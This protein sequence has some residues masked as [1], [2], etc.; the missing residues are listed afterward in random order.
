MNPPYKFSV[1]HFCQK[2]LY[3]MMKKRFS[4]FNY[5]TKQLKYTIEKN[6]I[7]SRRTLIFFFRPYN[8]KHEVD[9]E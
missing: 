6:Y 3:Q 7:I 1:Q 5:S 8:R 9:N 2:Y 4:C